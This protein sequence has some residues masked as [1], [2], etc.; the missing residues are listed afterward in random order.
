MF[1]VTHTNSG[2]FLLTTVCCWFVHLIGY[3]LRDE[4]REGKD[5]GKWSGF[6]SGYLYVEYQRDTLVFTECRCELLPSCVVLS[7]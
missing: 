6:P 1:K 4:G 3:N 7:N 5:Y 2:N